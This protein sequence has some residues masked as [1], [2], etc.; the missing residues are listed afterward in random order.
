MTY[1]MKMVR[2]SAYQDFQE[3]IEGLKET[4]RITSSA[5][6]ATTAQSGVSKSDTFA[7]TDMDLPPSLFHA[8]QELIK[9]EG[10]KMINAAYLERTYSCYTR[11][12]RFSN[13]QMLTV[14]A[15]L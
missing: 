11:T 7:A 8:I 15:T 9:N 10:S 6:E 12:F 4:E 2:E 13:I 3:S 14:F 5:E 1:F